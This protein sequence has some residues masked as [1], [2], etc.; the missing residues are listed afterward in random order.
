MVSILNASRNYGP[1]MVLNE[2]IVRS[3]SVASPAFGTPQMSGRFFLPVAAPYP[4]PSQAG[5]ISSP[6][7]SG[8]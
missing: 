3:T 2:T 7:L 4:A 1:I 8:L 6:L 5:P